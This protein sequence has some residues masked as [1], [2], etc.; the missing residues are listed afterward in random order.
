MRDDNMKTVYFVRHGESEVNAGDVWVGDNTRLTEKGTAQA[1][2]VASRCKTLPIDVIISS[3]LKR[4][5][6]TAE[7][8]KNK[9]TKPLEYSDLFAERKWPSEQVGLPKNHPKADEIK[10]KVWDD[11]SN[12][13]FRYS[14]EETFGDLKERIRKALILLEDRAEDNILV[15][16][17][18]FIMRIIVAYVVMGEELTAVECDQF[19]DKFHTK[20]TGLTVMHYGK[21]VKRTQWYF[22]VW[23][24]HAHLA[25]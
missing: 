21:K 6:D 1:E 19:I 4:A 18:G 23:N 8:I 22:S 3:T 16:T 25:D 10:R 14:D 15:V 9:I 7:I 13:E 5:V 24:D 20:N 17:H 2:Y 12:P 11:L